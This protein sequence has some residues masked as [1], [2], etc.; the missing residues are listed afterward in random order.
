MKQKFIH[1]R[2]TF[3]SKLETLSIYIKSLRIVKYRLKVIKMIFLIM[4][5]LFFINKLYLLEYFLI[6]KKNEQTVHRVPILYPFPQESHPS[7][8]IYL[9][10]KSP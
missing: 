6:Y 3:T 5:N 4:P 10:I 1:C 2:K 8:E 7:S 9:I